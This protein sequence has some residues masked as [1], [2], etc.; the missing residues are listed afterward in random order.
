MKIETSRHMSMAVHT[1]RIGRLTIKVTNRPQLFEE[2][3]LPSFKGWW[4]QVIR[5]AKA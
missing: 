3:R 1:V 4:V 2:N 5:R